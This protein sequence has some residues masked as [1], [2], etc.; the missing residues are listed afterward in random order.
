[1]PARKS[2]GNKGLKLV[3]VGGK[4][5]YAHPRPKGTKQHIDRAHL[6]TE[7]KQ[8]ARAVLAGMVE[9][10]QYGRFVR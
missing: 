8:R 4:S 3:H 5:F 9:R 10:D 6:P 2:K 7:L 1:M